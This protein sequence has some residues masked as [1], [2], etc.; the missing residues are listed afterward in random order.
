MENVHCQLFHLPA[1]RKAGETD[2]FS[3]RNK[4][5]PFYNL[6][7][8]MPGREMDKLEPR[9]N[10]MNKKDERSREIQDVFS[11]GARGEFYEIQVKGHLDESWSDWL[12]GLEVNLLD[13]G[14][15][16]LYG[17]IM[18]QAAL[19]GILNKLNGLNLTLLS[20]NECK[21]NNERR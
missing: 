16:I 8:M 12:E 18:D 4:Y 20:V 21:K 14:K 3:R 6:Q 5:N 13:N 7:T 10:M 9:G 17:H 2:H 1:L 15:M 11:T 19:M